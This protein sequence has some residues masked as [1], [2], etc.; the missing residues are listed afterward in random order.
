M[1]VGH[2]ARSLEEV[3]IATVTIAVAAFEGRL[4]PMRVPRRLLT[5]FPMGRPLGPPG[6]RATQRAVIERALRLVDEADAPDT[7]VRWEHPYRP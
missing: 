1:S 5:P 7:A 3:G 4:G 6:D 2:V